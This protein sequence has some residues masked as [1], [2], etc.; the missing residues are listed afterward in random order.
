MKEKRNNRRTVL[1]L[2]NIAFGLYIAR[3]ELITRLIQMDSKVIAVTP[4]DTYVDKLQEIGCEYINLEFN[5]RGKN[6]FNDIGILLRYVQLIK[7]TA[8]DVVLTYTI[9]PNVYGGLA[10]RLARI[11]YL[12]NITGLGTTI[13]N[14]GVLQ[15][16]ALS[17][18]KVGLKK[19]SCVFFQNAPNRKFF[20]ERILSKSCHSRTIPGSGVNLSEHIYEPYPSEANG[21]VFLFVGRIMKDKGIEELFSAAEMIKKKY[22]NTKF[23]IIGECDEDYSE[24]INELEKNGV[25][26]QL[27]FQK[28]VHSYMRDSHCVI[29]PSYHE[30]TSN[31]LLES[32]ACGRPVIATRVTG[33]SETFD[34]GITGFGCDVKSAESLVEAVERFLRQSPEEHEAMGKAGRAKMER[35]YDRQIV[36]DAY[37]DEIEKTKVK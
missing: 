1:I 36:V 17:L 31:V 16:I 14:P 34:D 33:C 30:G 19:A 29:L 4:F 3:K 25:I 28:D 21:V 9:K 22:S 6:V 24:R 27:G 20:S 10:C 12:A 32:A 8:P 13:E 7:E 5:R 37:M 35:E 23:R 15:F 18:Y 2:S 26:E 11:P